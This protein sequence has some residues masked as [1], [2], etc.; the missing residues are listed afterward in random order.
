MPGNRGLVSGKN[1]REWVDYAPRLDS[2]AGSANTTT[3]PS[4]GTNG[5]GWGRYLYDEVSQ[6]CIAEFGL[7]FGTSGLAQGA[8]PGCYYLVELPLP[9]KIEQPGYGINQGTFLGSNTGPT[10]IDKS[11]GYGWWSG[12]G[13]ET[14]NIPLNA[15]FSDQPGYSTGLDRNRLAQFFMPYSLFNG[16][17]SI[18]PA[19]TGV[20]QTGT[21]AGVIQLTIAAANLV[22]PGQVVTGSGLSGTWTVSSVVY[23]NGFGGAQANITG[24]TGT[25][26]A[27][28]T[29]TFTPASTTT[30]TITLPS[31]LNNIPGIGSQTIGSVA[32]Y[33]IQ[34]QSNPN[35]STAKGMH[36]L[37]SLSTTQ[38][39]VNLPVAPATTAVFQWKLRTDSQTLLGAMSA[40]PV[41]TEFIRGTF[42]YEVDL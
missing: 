29:Y 15:T 7:L 38:F 17:G 32:D 27:T 1:P 36:W 3:A 21:A 34:W 10:A 11:I 14:P 9:A 4:L 23:N 18:G 41:G 19:T 6:L 16:A 2:W 25:P 37:S 20:A 24:G 42:I 33:Q 30:C 5:A 26:T 39:T 28:S 13:F 31:T 12:S 8:G 40:A 22:A 35:A